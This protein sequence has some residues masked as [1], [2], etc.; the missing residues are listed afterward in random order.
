[1]SDQDR[2]SQAEAARVLGVNRSTV[3]RWCKAHP[4]LVDADRLVSIS[5]LE[6][7]RAALINPKLQTRGA[8][9]SSEPKPAPA[10][11]AAPVQGMSLNQ[12][13]ARVEAVKADSAELD[14]AE[15]LRQTLRRDEVEAAIADTGEKMKQAAAQLARDRAEALTRIEDV[16]EMEIALQEMTRAIFESLVLTLGNGIAQDGHDNAA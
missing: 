1:M 6:D 8:A 4:A 14:L 12:D 11:A 16:R 5:E 7:H 13:R 10:A 15:R 3:S 2:V 9:A